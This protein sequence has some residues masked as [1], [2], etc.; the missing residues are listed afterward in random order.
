MIGAILSGWR[1]LRLRL[2]AAKVRLRLRR[3][4]MRADVE[5]GPGVRYETLPLLEVHPYSPET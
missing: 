4:G 3:L 1:R 5:I 2:W